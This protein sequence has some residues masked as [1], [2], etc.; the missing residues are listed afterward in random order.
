MN[1]FSPKLII[2]G[3][4]AGAGKTTISRKLSSD[5]RLPIFSSDSF[6]KSL[7]KLTENY[8]NES[9]DIKSAI[10]PI[11]YD[12]LFEIMVYNIKSGLTLIL[13]ANMCNLQT[14][15]SVERL[16]K[17]IPELQCLLVILDIELEVA[18]SRI[19]KRKNSDPANHDLDSAGVDKIMAKYEFINNFDRPDLLR[20]DANRD[21]KILYNDVTKLV[22][23]FIKK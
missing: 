2:I 16:E 15:E 18:K 4:F 23:E 7:L 1:S 21:A 20:I 12:L 14:W 19:Q 6:G 13:D 17:D 5:F 11:A 3:G 22:Q 8:I 9:H 10:Y